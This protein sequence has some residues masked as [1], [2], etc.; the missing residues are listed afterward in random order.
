MRFRMLLGRT[1]LAGRF[2][3]DAGQSYLMG[4]PRKIVGARK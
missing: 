4:R 1:A 2:L 3:V